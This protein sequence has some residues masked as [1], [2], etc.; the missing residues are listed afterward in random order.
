MRLREFTRIF[1]AAKAIMCS[2]IE[3]EAIYGPFNYAAEG[4]QSNRLN[5]NIDFEIV[6]K[7][8]KRRLKITTENLMLYTAFQSS[9]LDLA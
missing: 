2:N 7:P 5:M 6:D 1:P 3:R 8:F 4:M 9:G